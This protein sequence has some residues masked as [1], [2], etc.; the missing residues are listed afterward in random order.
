MTVKEWLAGVFYVGDRVAGRNTTATNPTYNL[1]PLPDYTLVD[2]SAG[3]SG[4]KYAVRVKLTNVFD[5]LS[6]NVHDDNS[7]NP[8]APGQFSASFVYKL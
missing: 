8:I 1:M 2:V 4:N 7:V 5:K 3:Y 6:Y